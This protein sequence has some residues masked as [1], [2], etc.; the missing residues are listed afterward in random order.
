MF[1]DLDK[2]KE[3]LDSKRPLTNQQSTM[4]KKVFD[5]ELIYNSNAIKE[6]DYL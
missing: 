3:I 6:Q 1:K 5:V 4:L 2:K